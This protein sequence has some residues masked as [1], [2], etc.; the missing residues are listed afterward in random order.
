MTLTVQLF[1]GLKD[2]AGTSQIQVEVAAGGTVAD[3]LQA[4][5]GGYPGMARWVPHIRVAVNQEYVKTDSAVSEGDEVALIPPVSGGAA[6]V[7][8]VDRA[9]GLDEVVNPVLAASG[10]AAGAVCTFLGVVRSNSMDP[11]G[12]EHRDIEFLD[13][14]AYGPMAERE[15]ARIAG[16]VE[17]RWG[18]H[19]AMVHRTGRLMVG[20]A[21][22][23]I[24]VA[25]AHRAASFEACHY[26]ID[27]LKRSVPVWK[28]EQAQGGTWWVEGLASDS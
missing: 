8:V 11:E 10:G 20:E 12:R 27:E 22:V 24:A 13:Y 3:L 1:A 7:A 19:C 15:M 17:Q 23:A 5:A 25:T 14:E 18:G 6:Q 2:A 9:I 16:E 4:V 21:S 28:R 26:A